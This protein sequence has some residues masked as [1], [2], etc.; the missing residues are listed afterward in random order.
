MHQDVLFKSKMVNDHPKIYSLSGMQLAKERTKELN[1]IK[2]T[3]G[4]YIKKLF[5]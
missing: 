1:V 3:D 5:K 2:K 4:N